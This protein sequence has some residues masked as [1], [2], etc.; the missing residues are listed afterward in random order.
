MKKTTADRLTTVL[1]LAKLR[2]QQSAVRLAESIRNVQSNNLQQSQLQQYTAE[3]SQQ[4]KQQTGVSQSAAELANF[5][6]FYADL[7]RATIAQQ[8]RSV[9]ADDQLYQAKEEWQGLHA[10]GKNLQALIERTQ[11]QYDREQENAVQREMDDR[12]SSYK[13]DY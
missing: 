6:R 3:Y 11:Q 13:D 2:E 7:D 8:E 5:Q 4:F 12:V 9:L 1:K 10:K